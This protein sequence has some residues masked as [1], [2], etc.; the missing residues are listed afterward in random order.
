MPGP[1]HTIRILCMPLLP[2][3]AG[4]N[5]HGVGL[6]GDALAEVRALQNALEASGETTQEAQQAA[7]ALAGDG[8]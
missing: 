5:S 2:H 3:K 8:G 7:A 4:S 1:M 6:V